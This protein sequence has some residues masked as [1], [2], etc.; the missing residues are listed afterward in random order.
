MGLSRQ[1]ILYLYKIS[2]RTCAYLCGEKILPI[3][4]CMNFQLVLKAK[5]AAGLV[6]ID[7]FQAGIDF[8]LAY[9]E[10]ILEK[11]ICACALKGCKTW[12]LL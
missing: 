4:E 2:L 11:K 10:I 1:F 3:T 9:H 6:C 8:G 12:V 7:V 5:A